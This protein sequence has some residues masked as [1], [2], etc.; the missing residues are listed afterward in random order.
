MSSAKAQLKAIGDAV[1]KNQFDDA[2]ELSRALIQ[3]DSKNYLGY[4][5]FSPSSNIPANI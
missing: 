5:Q 3:K 4:G 1:K 2:I